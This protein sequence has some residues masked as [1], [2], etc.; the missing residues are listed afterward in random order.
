MRER[1]HLEDPAIDGRIVVKQIFK[2]WDGSFEW[3]DLAQGKLQILL[4][5]VMKLQVPDYLT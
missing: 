3:I 5:A 4:L 1:D 2:K